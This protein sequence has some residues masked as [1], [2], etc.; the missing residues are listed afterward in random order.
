MALAGDDGQPVS[1]QGF[2]IS[3]WSRP[4][5]K[6]REEQKRQEEDPEYTKFVQHNIGTKISLQ[7]RNFNRSTFS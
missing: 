4:Q 2:R 6:I 1:I 7:D 3:G 5:D